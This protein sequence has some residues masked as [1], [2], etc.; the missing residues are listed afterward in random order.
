M[1]RVN[2]A[3]PPRPYSVVIESGLLSEAG[4]VLR[5]IYSGPRSL[6]VI[7]VPPVRRRWGTKLMKA[8]SGAGFSVKLIEMP[9][10]ERRKKLATVEMLAEKLARLGARS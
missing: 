7:T 6:F 8:L 10:G 3:T 1:P 4:S 2:V 5:E 9:D